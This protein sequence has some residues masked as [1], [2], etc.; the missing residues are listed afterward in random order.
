M[1]YQQQYQGI[2]LLA[3]DQQD[4]FDALSME[5]A[6]NLLAVNN[7]YCEQKYQYPAEVYWFFWG[8][9]DAGPYPEKLS[10]VARISRS[11]IHTRYGVAELPPGCSFSRHAG[12]VISDLMKL[13]NELKAA[14][15][16]LE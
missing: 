15:L 14:M 16:E 3:M 9:P 13:R 7:A 10:E 1:I 11:I 12:P 2:E 5:L 6:Q 8:F 4:A